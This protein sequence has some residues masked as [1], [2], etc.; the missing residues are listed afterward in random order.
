MSKPR[1]IVSRQI[2]PDVVA[3][4]HE[5]YDCP[6]T[7]ADMDA[8]TL[9]RAVKEHRADAL[10]IT[11]HL[12]FRKDVIDRLPGHIRIVATC[13]VGTDHIESPAAKARGLPMTNTPDVLTECTA[14]LA[15]M[16]MLNAFRRG[17]E[18]DRV[19]REGW[20]VHYGLG[21][22]MGRRASGKTLGLV[23]C[24]KTLCVRSCFAELSRL[25]DAG[26]LPR[27]VVVEVNAASQCSTPEALY[28]L[29]WE[30]LGPLIGSSSLFPLF[31]GT[32]PRAR[33]RLSEWGRGAREEH[34]RKGRSYP[35]RRQDFSGTFSW[36]LQPLM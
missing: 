22:M 2:P 8:D 5:E 15:F 28:P 14:D 19:M 33:R 6:Y 35:A 4:I 10:M 20:R 17:Y 3:R 18:Y 30:K 13:S 31:N 23:G 32:A 24:G 34:L 16:L 7:G 1:L 12:P 25:A 27:F 26:A 11:S 21:E 36:D 29:V 9:I